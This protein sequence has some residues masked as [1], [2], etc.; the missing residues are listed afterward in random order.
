[1]CCARTSPVAVLA[2][3]SSVFRSA[4]SWF[5]LPFIFLI[6]EM[7]SSIRPA[8]HST[9]EL[10]TTETRIKSNEMFFSF[11]G[12]QYLLFFFFFNY[13][14]REL[15]PLGNTQAFLGS[16]LSRHRSL[17]SVTPSYIGFIM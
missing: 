10:C 15:F 12:S 1:M 8:L 9:E 16:F 4:L 3:H 17:S 5:S 13:S 14:S 2:L 6:M 7:L 11:C